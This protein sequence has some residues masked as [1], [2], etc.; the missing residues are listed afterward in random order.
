MEA[1]IP[2]ENRALEKAQNTYNRVR[3]KYEATKLLQNTNKS[4]DL[5]KILNGLLAQKNQAYNELIKAEEKYQNFRK[6]L[7]QAAQDAHIYI[8]GVDVNWT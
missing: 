3:D 4:P 5:L 6:N 8:P 2:E 7:I 1:L